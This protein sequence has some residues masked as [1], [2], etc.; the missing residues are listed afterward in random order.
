MPADPDARVVPCLI[1]QKI[2]N[3]SDPDARDPDA[4]TPMPADPDAREKF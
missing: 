4:R 2:L 3:R 1:Q